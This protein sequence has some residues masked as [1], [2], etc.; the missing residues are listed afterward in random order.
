MAAKNA[1]LNKR[2]NKRR[3]IAAQRR[4]RAVE[5]M[6]GENRKTLR[7]VG[8]ELGV[9][10]AAVWKMVRGYV[11]NINATNVEA[12]AVLRQEMLD[13]LEQAI[14]G[15]LPKA[16]E[17]DTAAAAALVRLFE[18]MAKLAG[19]DA[20]DKYEHAGVGGTP[21]N[22]AVMLIPAPKKEEDL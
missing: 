17:G 6:T 10:T 7:E 8:S 11:D 22:S 20:P 5:L 18:R 2:L 12:V 19:L 14:Q 15:Q 3:I 9:T 16:R 1:S 21:L 13:R 4:L